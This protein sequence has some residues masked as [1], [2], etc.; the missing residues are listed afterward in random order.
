MAHETATYTCPQCRRQICVLADEYGDHPCSC[1]WDPDY[2][3]EGDG[4]DMETNVIEK[5]RELIGDGYEGEAWD[6]VHE[7]VDAIL[8][9][10]KPKGYSVKR[11]D[12]E[13]E[14]GGRWSN[15]KTTVY[16][17]EQDGQVAHFSVWREEPATEMQDGMDLALQINEVVPEEVTVIKYVPGR[18]A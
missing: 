18:A 10:Y 11:V 15:Y 16:R 1:G 5:L 9:V 12:E 2:E 4:E 13:F 17:V 14:D 7:D 8:G 6:E 3:N